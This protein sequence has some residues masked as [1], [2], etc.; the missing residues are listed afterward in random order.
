MASGKKGKA[1]RV[2]VWFILLLL[3]VGLAGFGATNFGGTV[4][5]IGK[6]GDT[7]IDVTRYARALQQQI[8]AI[9]QQTG[10]NLTLA[11]AQQFGLDQA[12]LQQLIGTVALEN[13]AKI[14]GLSVGDEQVRNQVLQIPAFQGVDGKFS[15]E[16]Y[17]FALEQSGLKESAFE[18]TLRAEVARTM[19]QGAVASGVIAPKVLVD[20]ILTFI[21]ERRS[22][23]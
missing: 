20:T 5:S 22:F 15:R 2:V 16:N 4:N 18:A 10:Q 23:A 9:S 13:E 14:L 6:V 17:R 21:A 19:I 12:V 11:Q 7:P 8:N 1:S 3:I